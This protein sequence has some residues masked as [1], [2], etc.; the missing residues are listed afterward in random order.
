MIKVVTRIIVILLSG[1]VSL[2]INAQDFASESSNRN[3]S[4]VWKGNEYT[5][6]LNMNYSWIFYFN[7]IQE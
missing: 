4:N 6:K 2:S 5:P 3:E 1:C 7:D